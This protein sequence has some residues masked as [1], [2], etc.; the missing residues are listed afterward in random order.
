MLLKKTLEEM[1][2]SYGIIDGTLSDKNKRFEIQSR[3]IDGEISVL[4]INVTTTLDLPSDYCI[5]YELCDA[6]TVTQFIGRCI[7]GLDSSE[8]DVHFILTKDTYEIKY[9]YNSIWKKSKYLQDTLGKDNI[10]MNEIKKL[11]DNNMWQ[12]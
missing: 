8:L 5:F 6:G 4:I 9:F 7:R 1:D 2:I 10:V 11:V 12:S 3:Y